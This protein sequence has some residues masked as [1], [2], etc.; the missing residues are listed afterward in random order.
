VEGQAHLQKDYFDLTNPIFPEK[1]FRRRYRMSRDLFLLILR[2]ARNYDP[3][4]QCRR[5]ATG[6]LGFTSYQKCSAPIRM[7]SYGMAADIFDEYL[8]MGQ[9]TCLEAMYMFCRAVIAVFREY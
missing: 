6:A 7:L 3:Y 9:S 5:Y 8:R 4:F 2:G 1:M